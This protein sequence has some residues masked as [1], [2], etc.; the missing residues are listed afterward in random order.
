[1]LSKEPVTYQQANRLSEQ[2]KKFEKNFGLKLD[3]KANSDVQNCQPLKATRVPFQTTLRLRW[4]TGLNPLFLAQWF[5]KHV[6]ALFK[7]PI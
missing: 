3:A 6:F 7:L 1:M 4:G 2:T 5:P